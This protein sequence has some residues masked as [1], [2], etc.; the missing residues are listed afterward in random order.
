MSYE[1]K[2]IKYKN[3]YLKLK[4]LS[5]GE[6]KVKWNKEVWNKG[7]WDENNN[8][9]YDKI[10]KLLVINN[11]DNN[12]ITKQNTTSMKVNLGDEINQDIQVIIN[13]SI[14]RIEDNAFENMNIIDLQF[15]NLNNTQS[16]LKYI[17]KYAFANNKI[18][19]LNLPSSI[20]QID[21]FAFSINLIDTFNDDIYNFFYTIKWGNNVFIN[22][23][24][25]IELITQNILKNIN[26][27]KNK[28]HIKIILTK[29]EDKV[30]KPNKIK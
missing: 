21:D 13:G 30:N 4:E 16:Q 18:K 27:D 11:S 5:G 6:D 22:N 15:N 29:D 1:K 10:N 17:G 19:S 9:K 7:V 8:Y 28:N 2:Y 25:N 12:I 26:N 24:L 3:K 23:K 20:Q 14:E